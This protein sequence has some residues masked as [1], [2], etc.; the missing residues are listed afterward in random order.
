MQNE[1]TSR[2]VQLGNKTILRALGWVLLFVALAWL[3]VA[4]RQVLLLTFAGILLGVALAGCADWLQEHSPFSRGWSLFVVC[5]VLV[6]V[7]A[8]GLW[9]LGEQ[10]AKQANQ[11]ADRVPQAVGKLGQQVRQHPLG[12]KL[13]G[14]ARQAQQAGQ[15]QAQELPRKL[16][17]VLA[18]VMNAAGGIV[19]FF[20][21]G[22]FFAANPETYRCGL[23]HLIPLSGR[24]RGR[25][26][27]DQLECTLRRWLLGLCASMASAAV[28]TGLALWLLKV[29]MALVLGILAGVGE[30]VPNFGPLAAAVPAVLLSLVDSP[31]RAGLVV[32]AYVVIQTVQ[33][34]LITPMVQD[35]AVD[36]PPAVLIVTQVLMGTVLGPLGLIVATPLMVVVMVVVRMLYV[37]DALGDTSLEN[38]TSEAS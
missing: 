16:G 37:D 9:G 2:R 33:S 26:V 35:K 21:L 10:V 7:V 20:F 29:P 15:Q 6:A 14:P 17:Q 12:A 8:G 23:M 31:A 25:E 13:V 3:A 32:L 24:K 5:V 4:G 22:L 27:L 18:Q 34:Y 19:L 30:I 28:M 36:M 1:E 38:N 11:L